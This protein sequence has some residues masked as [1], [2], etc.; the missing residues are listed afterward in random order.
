MVGTGY[1]SHAFEE[2]LPFILGGIKIDAPF[3]C[4]AHSDGDAL[5]HALVD[6]LLGAMGKG[7]IGELY[8]DTDDKFKNADSSRFL[9]ETIYLMKSLFYEIVNIDITILLE[10]PK[11]KEYKAL[12][13]ENLAKLCGIE[14]GLINIKAKTNER[15]GFVGR[16]EG[17]A[18][19]CVCQIEKP[20]K[21]E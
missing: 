3:G 20:A 13:R 9:T 17:I 1:D 21:S 15:M 11:L 18:V 16:S 2:N 6:A 12:I 19:L 5:M 4:R 8:P 7:D 10:K 14:T